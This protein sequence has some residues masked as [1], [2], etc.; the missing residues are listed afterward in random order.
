MG[1]LRQSKNNTT[2]IGT[3]KS[4]DYKYGTTKAG[5]AFIAVTLV[6][7]SKVADKITEHK[8][9][10]WTKES[11]KLAKGYKTIIDTY[12]T[13]DADG[14]EAAD[15]VKVV[16]S[17]EPNE[18]MKDGELKVF[19]KIKGL[20]VNRLDGSTEEDIS[21]VA[22]EGVLVGSRPEIK[23]GLPT[24]RLLVTFYSVGY[25]N[26]INEYN[27]LIIEE[28]MAESFKKSIPEL[29]T[30]IAHVRLD[31]FV[32]IE[33]QAPTQQLFGSAL[34]GID[35]VVKTYV[36]EDIMVG[37]MPVKVTEKY[38][39]EQIMEMKK[40]R[41]LQLAEKRVAAPAASETF[42][43]GAGFGGAMSDSDLPF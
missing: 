37:A 2:I 6:V 39:N 43:A 18:Y 41:E 13:I 34:S 7:V 28:A 27:D 12:K 16:G 42:N 9:E 26:T 1:T 24:G 15:R 38:T 35:N 40:H 10:L 14:E 17:Y 33:E 20:F 11:S 29:S 30:I 22:I 5:D 4:I 23:A 3:L 36:N 8:V 25:N 19:K 21:G 32:V 31:K